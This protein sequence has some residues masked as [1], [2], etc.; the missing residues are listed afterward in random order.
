MKQYVGLDVSRK[1]TSVCVVNEVGQVLLEGKAKSGPGG[2]ATPQRAPHAARIGFDTGAM[3]S[4]LWHENARGLAEL[5]RVGWY[6]EVKVKGEESQKIRALLLARSA[7]RDPPGYREP[8]PQPDQRMRAA[9]STRDR[10]CSSA[11]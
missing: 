3:A 6:R 1:K 7:H 10:V 9:V 5:V 4:W 11:I 2:T 8:G